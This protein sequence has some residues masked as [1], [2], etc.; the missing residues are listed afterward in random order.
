MS[1]RLLFTLILLAGIA[2]VYLGKK[3]KEK[4]KFVFIIA[5]ILFVLFGGFGVF[6]SML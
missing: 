1:P 4:I 2:F 3:V 5:G 6:T